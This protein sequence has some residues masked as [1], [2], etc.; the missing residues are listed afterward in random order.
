MSMAI[1]APPKIEHGESGRGPN[2]PTRRDRFG[3]DGGGRFDPDLPNQT[4]YTGM[5]LAL[6]GITMFF[7]AFISAY[8][9]RQGLSD[10][11]Q[12]I[13]IPWLLWLNTAVLVISTV[14]MEAARKSFPDRDRLQRW[15][16]V[17]TL[18]GLLFLLGQFLVW[19]ELIS[20]GVYVSTNPSSSFFYLLTGSHG[21][22]LL[23]GVV[24]LVYFYRRF[25]GRRSS[26]PG[27]AA[28]DV[29]ALYWHSMDALWVFLLIFILVW[30]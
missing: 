8:V 21:V 13:Q 18:L 15:W 11:W 5:L 1:P 29:T 24:A 20:A 19:L 2:G 7:A 10:D 3:G 30:R 22:H 6:G 26:P 27:K 23:G 16:G 17:T 25:S 14:T 9:V 4:Y 12:P 28:V